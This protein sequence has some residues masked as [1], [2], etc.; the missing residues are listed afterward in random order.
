MRRM[1][2]QVCGAFSPWNFG[3]ESGERR[4]DYINGKVY[5]I[6]E[7]NGCD[8]RRIGELSYHEPEAQKKGKQAVQ[9][10]GVWYWK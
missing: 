9:I 5:D 6:T 7:S 3:I 1:R 10:D 4:Y 8:K 2:K